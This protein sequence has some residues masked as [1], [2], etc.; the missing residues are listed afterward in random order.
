V[1]RDVLE[2]LFRAVGDDAE[3]ELTTAA[4]EHFGRE[5]TDA[6]KELADVAET[7]GTDE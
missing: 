4:T 6:A 3:A 7:I 1:T 2:T 5:L